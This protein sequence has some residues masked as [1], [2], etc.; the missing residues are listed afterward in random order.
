MT[1]SRARAAWLIVAASISCFAWQAASQQPAPREA[2]VLHWRAP[3]ECPSADRI[4]NAIQE[5][6]GSKD[7]SGRTVIARAEVWRGEDAA[8]HVSIQT[9]SAQGQGERKV[10]GASCKAVSDAS[11]LIIAMAIDPAAVMDRMGETPPAASASSSAPVPTASVSAPTPQ[12]APKAPPARAPLPS[13]NRTRAL[14][15][16]PRADSSW[17]SGLA[18]SGAAVVDIGSL[19]TASPGGELTLSALGARF[20]WELS[21]RYFSQVSDEYADRPVAGGEF[22]LWTVATAGCRDWSR[23]LWGW[24]ACGGMEA[25][26]MRAKG[27][28]VT[29]PSQASP[30]WVALEAGG[31]GF[32]RVYSGLWLRAHVGA[33][34]PLVRR[35]FLIAP[36][37][38]LHQAWPV[39]LR[40]SF[41]PELRFP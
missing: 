9:E 22:R 31:L 27:F 14:E 33:V 3:S 10:D 16:L 39:E 25:G 12:P 29:D 7:R 28:G 15:P 4:R 24:S 8:W 34:V 36:Y 37:G 19:P 26:S 21:G 18:A 5:L 13:W 23:G 6:I 11:A 30:P 40:A 20:R 32:L 1:R 38:E 17:P 35:H 41:G 2:F